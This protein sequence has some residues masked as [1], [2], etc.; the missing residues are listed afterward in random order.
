M[1]QRSAKIPAESSK[2]EI[3]DYVNQHITPIQSWRASSATLKVTGVPIPLSA[4]MAVEQPNHFR[5][6][7]AGVLS[8]QNELDLGSNQEKL[9]FWARQMEPK[10]VI[11]CRHE[12][13]E[14]V[15]DQLPV[16]FQPEWL[17][18]VMCV[19]PISCENADLVRDPEDSYSVKLVSHH[20]NAS[21]ST[22][23][24][25]STIDLRKGEVRRHQLYDSNH[26]LLVSAE[27]SD[28]REFPKTKARLPHDI[29]LRWVQQDMKM[30]ITLNGVEINPPHMPEEIWTIPV[31][32]D[33]PVHELHR[34]QLLQPASGATPRSLREKP[35]AITQYELDSPSG[36]WVQEQEIRVPG[37]AQR[38]QMASTQ[39]ATDPFSVHEFQPAAAT[40]QPQRSSEPAG[41]VSLSDLQ[42]PPFPGTAI[43]AGN[44]ASTVPGQQVVM[45]TAETPEWAQPASLK[46]SRETLIDG[47]PASEFEPPVTNS[48]AN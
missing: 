37:Q 22:V 29:S 19:A 44:T 15:Q 17:M 18:Q 43:P 38:Q 23:R 40:T 36:A 26:Q 28:Y 27:L 20:T 3:V 41:K 31:I 16:P 48:A 24:K 34:D 35:K 8:G 11:T 33:C 13:I 7:V 9:W 42:P 30:H 45:Q 32:A 6:T 10:A 2:E 5:L 46:K 12:E 25:I 4:M 39:A 1:L 21:G 47:I 14:A